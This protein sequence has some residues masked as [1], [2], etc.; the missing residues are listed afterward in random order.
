MSGLRD[1][2]IKRYIT[3][4]ASKAENDRKYGV[5]KR[6]VGG[7]IYEMKNS[8]KDHKDRNRHKSR[9]KRSGQARLVYV[10]DKLQHPHHVKVSLRGLVQES[11]AR[12]ESLKQ[13]P[14]YITCC[15]RLFYLLQLTCVEA[16][17]FVEE[18]V[19]WLCPSQVRAR[20][21]TL[22]SIGM[23]KSFWSW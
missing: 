14:W 12:T 5:R 2:F 13:N 19:C 7:G 22:L 8:W 3:E 21:L 1:T 10:K 9:I 18:T 15:F 17:P 20:S 23:Q 16:A 11:S 6:R 4:R